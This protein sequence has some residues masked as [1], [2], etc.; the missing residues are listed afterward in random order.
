L[1]ILKKAFFQK[2]FLSGSRATP[3]SRS[4]ERE[5]PLCVS[6]KAT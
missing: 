6:E 4:A 2:S 5:I 1:K 3:L